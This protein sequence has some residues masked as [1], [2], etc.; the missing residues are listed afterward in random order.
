MPE[1]EEKKKME[2]EQAKTGTTKE[3]GR[4]NSRIELSSVYTEL[5]REAAVPEG[6][7]AKLRVYLT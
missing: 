7:A 6:P 2:C 1:K 3:R 5:L 4:R